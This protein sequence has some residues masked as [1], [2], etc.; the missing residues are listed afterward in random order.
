MALV[1]LII[2]L[3]IRPDPR[4]IALE[5]QAADSASGAPEHG[6]ARLR[7]AR[8][9]AVPASPSR[10]DRRDREL[11]RHGRRDEPHRVHRR[12]PPP[13]AGGRLHGHQPRTSSACTRSSSSSA[14][15]SIGSDG[16]RTLLWGTRDHGCCSTVMLRLRRVDRVDVRLALPARARLEPLVHLGHRRARDLRD[17]RSSAVARRLHRSRRGSDRAPRLL[18]VGGLA[19]SEWGVVAIAVGATLAVVPGHPHAARPTARPSRPVEKGRLAP[20]QSSS[21]SP[22][23][24]LDAFANFVA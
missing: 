10:G 21:S 13:R 4:T 5:L 17:A 8:S 23:V 12:R 11:R 15:S 19:Y 3:N 20:F 6:S 1:G 2:A 9:C 18:F 22:G 16:G 7:S 24:Q 14:R